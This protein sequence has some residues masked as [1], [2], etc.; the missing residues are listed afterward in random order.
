[1]GLLPILGSADEEIW[2]IVVA[3]LLF[4]SQICQTP[5]PQ[6]SVPVC[7]DFMYLT[8]PSSRASLF[9]KKWMCSVI[10]NQLRESSF[11]A[12]GLN[13]ESV[14]NF[15]ENQCK[16]LTS[17]QKKEIHTVHMQFKEFTHKQTI[18]LCFIS[19]YTKDIAFFTNWQTVAT[20]CWK[21]NAFFQQHF[22]TSCHCVTFWKF[23]QHFTTFHYYYIPVMINDL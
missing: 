6:V 10:L 8:L 14:S 21:K 18:L 11:K 16:L 9:C 1:M 19:F 7:R 20:L 4:V 23:S 22:L 13:P 2:P 12:R 15:S 17:S 5:R 3:E